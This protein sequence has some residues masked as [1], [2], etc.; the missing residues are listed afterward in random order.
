MLIEQAVGI[1]LLTLPA[2]IVGY[3]LLRRTLPV[4]YFLAALVL[5]GTGY[6]VVTGAATDIGRATLATFGSGKAPVPAR[7][8]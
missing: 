5:V 3:A 2:L 6:L 7:A 4:F 1:L 8:G